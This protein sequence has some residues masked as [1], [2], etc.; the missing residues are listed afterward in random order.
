M[1]LAMMGVQRRRYR[2]RVNLLSGT[3]V[4]PAGVTTVNVLAYAQ[5][6][7]AATGIAAGGIFLGGMAG[8]GGGVIRNCTFTSTP[9]DTLT[10]TTTL[11][12]PSS[13]SHS[14][15]T[16]TDGGGTVCVLQG[17]HAALS[18]SS[19]P[20]SGGDVTWSRG[21]SVTAAGGLGGTALQPAGSAGGTAAAAGGLLI[22]GGGGGRGGALYPAASGGAGGAADAYAGLPADGP[23]GG[24]GGGVFPGAMYITATSTQR[25]G[26]LPSAVFYVEHD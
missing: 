19:A 5:G 25:P 18:A 21:G 1:M 17:G 7:A 8:G 15:Y 26:T 9:G 14:I 20:G 13:D 24:G 16:L 12:N 10:V 6:G 11:G 23:D 2:Y 4:V 3:Y 22:A